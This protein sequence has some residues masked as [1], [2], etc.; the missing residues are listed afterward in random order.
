MVQSDI[1]GNDG[2]VIAGFTTYAFQAFDSKDNVNTGVP[3][4]EAAW[5]FPVPTKPDTPGFGSYTPESDL[6]V[7]TL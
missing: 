3:D 7:L 6:L 2:A 1:T 5:V 4:E